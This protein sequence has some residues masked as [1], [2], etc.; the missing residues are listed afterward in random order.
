MR[1]QGIWTGVLLVW[2]IFTGCRAASSKKTAE[3]LAFMAESES[4]APGDV[5]DTVTTVNFDADSAYSYL[6]RQ[7][8]FG[9]R[10]PNTEAHR[11]AGDWLVSELKRHGAKVTEQR[12]DLM[13]FDGTVLKARNIFGQYNPESKDRI[14]LLAHWD[15]RPWADNDPD[16]AKRKQPVDGAN[17][18]ASGVAVLLEIAR[19]LHREGYDKGI[20]I[21]FV[22]AEDWGTD[23]DDESWAL[24]TRYFASHLPVKG[25]APRLGILL[26]MVGGEGATFCREYFSERS[27]PTET[28][29]IWQIATASGYG[30]IFLNRMGTAV[31]DDHVELIRAGIPAI[32]IIEYHPDGESGFNPRWHT[33]SDN[34]QGISKT[35]LE[36]VGKTLMQYLQY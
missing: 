1:R 9:P 35:T 21:L 16:P 27:A 30:D 18:G 33:A 8:E 14:L 34:L 25:Y 19:Q 23:G 36:A 24:G 22:D 4:V 3:E 26:D 12:A 2:I 15:S 32:D 17:D 31:M 28:E 7:V 10:V 20:D 5:M 11:N 6:S 29:R 13:A